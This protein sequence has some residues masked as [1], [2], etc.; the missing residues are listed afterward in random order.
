MSDIGFIDT[1][2]ECLEVFYRKS[3]SIEIA[4]KDAKE[5]IKALFEKLHKFLSLACYN[6]PH[7]KDRMSKKHIRELF[8]L[9]EQHTIS[10]LSYD[11]TSTLREILSN[12]Q[13]GGNSVINK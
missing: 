13:R 4:S 8:R 2:I 10:E 3:K 1:V 7:V 12:S 11:D 9:A 6:N 5:G